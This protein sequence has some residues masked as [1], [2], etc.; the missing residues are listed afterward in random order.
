MSELKK[1]FLESKDALWEKLYAE[2]GGKYRI[3]PKGTED[4]DAVEII[5][6]GNVEVQCDNWVLKIS[7]GSGP[8]SGPGPEPLTYLRFPGGL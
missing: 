8:G 3:P 7:I 5:K 6:G 4:T 1:P 2:L